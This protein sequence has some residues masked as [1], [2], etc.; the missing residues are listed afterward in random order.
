M[1]VLTGPAD[2]AE[3]GQASVPCVRTT[4]TNS[5]GKAPGIRTGF[6]ASVTPGPRRRLPLSQWYDDFDGPDLDTGVWLPHYLPAWSSREASA[7]S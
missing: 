2:G 5:I 7:A 4:V 6:P 3:S 1:Q